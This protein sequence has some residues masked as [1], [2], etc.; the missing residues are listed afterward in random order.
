VTYLTIVGDVADP[1]ISRVSELLRTRGVSV[2]VHSSISDIE[3]DPWPAWSSRSGFVTEG[4]AQAPP[5]TSLWWFRNKVAFLAIANPDDQRREFEVAT[6]MDYAGDMT[7][8]ARSRVVNRGLAS[9]GKLGQLA[10]A[11]HLGARIPETL[12]SND[13]TRILEFVESVGR[14]IVKPYS[15]S[16]ANPI[17]GIIKTRIHLMTNTVS[18][19]EIRAASEDDIRSSPAIYQREIRKSHELRVA[20]FGD[21]VVGYRINSQKFEITQLDWRRGEQL[22]GVADAEPTDLPVE[23]C[24]FVSNFL[25]LTR[26]DCGM[27]DFAVDH[28]GNWIFFECNPNGQWVALERD[29]RWISALFAAGMEELAAKLQQGAL[30]SSSHQRLAVEHERIRA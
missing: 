9:C 2:S 29:S 7:L 14:A 27:F 10:A 13:R 19:E 4:F 18:A 8:A 24:A 23:L 16:F 21:R 1:H 11:Q 3:H 26:L 17:M 5:E 22:E 28:D 25:K 15:R 12:I 20:A 6:R 30:A